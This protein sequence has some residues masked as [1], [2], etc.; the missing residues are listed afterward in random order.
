MTFVMLFLLVT[1]SAKKINCISEGAS[2]SYFK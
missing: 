1:T 2:K